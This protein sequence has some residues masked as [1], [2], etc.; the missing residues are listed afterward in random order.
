MNRTAGSRRRW[1]LIAPLF[2]LLTHFAKADWVEYGTEFGSLLML[3]YYD[4]TTAQ[5]QGDVVRVWIH[6]ELRGPMDGVRS[7][8]AL[9]EIRC[10]EMRHRTLQQTAFS[11]PRMSGELVRNHTFTDP[12]EWRYFGRGSEYARLQGMVCR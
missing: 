4:P 10:N 7:R 1:L 8:R 3:S 2:L 6:T 9:K 5:S 11:G 12:G